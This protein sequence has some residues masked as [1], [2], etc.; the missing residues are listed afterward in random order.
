VL[1]KKDGLMTKRDLSF[2]FLKKRKER[3][4]RNQFILLSIG[5]NKSAT[6]FCSI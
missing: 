6:D 5:A 2:A 1:V 4:V 3:K